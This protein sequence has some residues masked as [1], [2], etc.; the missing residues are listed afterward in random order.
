MKYRLIWEYFFF[1]IRNN[2]KEIGFIG[3]GNKFNFLFKWVNFDLVIVMNLIFEFGVFNF[4]FV[5]FEF[6]VC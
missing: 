1:Y 4:K 6:G 3:W 2:V 5:F